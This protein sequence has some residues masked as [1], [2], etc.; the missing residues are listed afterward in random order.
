MSYARMAANVGFNAFKA[1]AK[2]GG[3]VMGYGGRGAELFGTSAFGRS[4]QQIGAGLHQMGKGMSRGG[5]LYGGRTL[6][7]SG[8][9]TALTDP[10]RNL[11]R[12]GMG[13][14]RAGGAGMWNWASQG[15]IGQRAARLGTGYMAGRTVADFLNPWGIGFGD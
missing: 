7:G 15:T 4:M 12:M 6:L 2:A 13:N 11:M 8:A 9:S 5:S 14:I 1:L 3:K 10:G